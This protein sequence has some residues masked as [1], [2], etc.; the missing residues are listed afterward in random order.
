MW[1]QARGLATTL[2]PLCSAA[3]ESL[4]LRG[5]HVRNYDVLTNRS[6]RE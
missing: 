6:S 5:Q 2:L 3:V 4:D 1:I